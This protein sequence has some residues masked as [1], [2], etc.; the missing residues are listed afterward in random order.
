MELETKALGSR[1]RGN[2]ERVSFVHSVSRA[3]DE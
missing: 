1:L 2:D 3:E